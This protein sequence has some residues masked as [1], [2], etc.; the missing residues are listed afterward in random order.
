MLY[1]ERNDWFLCYI[2]MSSWPGSRSF[3]L[4]TG[5]QLLPEPAEYL[6]ANFALDRRATQLGN[7]RE[8][9]EDLDTAQSVMDEVVEAVKVE[10]VPFFN[11]FANLETYAIAAEVQA[12]TMNGLNCHFHERLCYVRLLAGDLPGALVAATA[13]VKTA[14]STT[15][16]T[17][18]RATSASGS[19][20][21]RQQRNGTKLGHLGYSANKPHTRGRAFV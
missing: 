8:L 7:I 16:I 10:A 17:T 14:P 6:I 13:A 19:N 1:Q 18:G 5:I 12:L 4:Q 11:Q 15:R 2:A 21:S 20:G 3:Y 9:P